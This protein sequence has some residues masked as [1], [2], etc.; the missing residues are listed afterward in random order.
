M[1]ISDLNVRS[2]ERGFD[3]YTLSSPFLEIEL[4]RKP[5]MAFIVAFYTLA[6]VVS[7]GVLY[8]FAVTLPSLIGF[9]TTVLAGIGMLVLASYDTGG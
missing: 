8:L 9:E 4:E 1:S 2:P 7:V 6:V 5:P 3:T